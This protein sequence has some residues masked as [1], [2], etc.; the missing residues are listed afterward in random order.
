MF[1][2]M[3]QNM[4]MTC[5]CPRSHGLQYSQPPLLYPLSNYTLLWPTDF[6]I[7]ACATLEG[8][9]NTSLRDFEDYS[10]PIRGLINNRMHSITTF[11]TIDTQNSNNRTACKIER[12]TNRKMVVRQ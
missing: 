9:S 3:W 1:I 12:T 4:R 7:L 8:R 5:S 2:L 6:L 10:W 11:G